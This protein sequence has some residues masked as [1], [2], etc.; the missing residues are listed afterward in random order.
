MLQPSLSLLSLLQLC[1]TLATEVDVIRKH[2]WNYLDR[3]LTRR[4]GVNDAKA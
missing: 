4:F 3:D 1:Q 2:Y